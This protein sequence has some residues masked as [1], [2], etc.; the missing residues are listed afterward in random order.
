MRI[1]EKPC[2][3]LVIFEALGSKIRLDIIELLQK[4]H[5]MNMNDIAES[6]SLSKSSLTPHIKKLEKAGII[7]IRLCSKSRGSQK[8]CRLLEDKYIFNIMPEIIEQKFYEIDLDVGKYAD[9]NVA[10]TCGLCSTKKVIG[11]FDDP[12]YFSDPERFDANII[13]FAQGYVTYK[14]PNQLP[15]DS[16]AQEIQIT[17]EL[18][19][20]A[21]GVISYYPSDIYFIVNGITL[22]FYTSPGEFFDR[23]GRFTPSWWFKNFPQ[24]GKAKVITVNETGTYLDGL[25]LSPITISELKLNE[26]PEISIKF[27]VKSDSEHVGGVTLLGKGFGDYNMG[28]KTKVLYSDKKETASK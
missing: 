26:I 24:Y 18:C 13:W 28:I 27:E 11:Y 19:S 20:E 2:D 17:V 8:L 6:L 12:R 4:K 21:P 5:E 10:P 22:G 14:I 15:L 1:I 23:P 7:S 25:F 9:Y 16:S 3:G